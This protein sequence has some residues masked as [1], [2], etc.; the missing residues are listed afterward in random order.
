MIDNLKHVFRSLDQKYQTKPEARSPRKHP[1]GQRR[2]ATYEHFM[3]KCLVRF[4]FASVDV[5]GH[6]VL[7][8]FSNLTCVWSSAKAPG[9]NHASNC[10]IGLRSAETV[11]PPLTAVFKYLEF[12]AWYGIKVFSMTPCMFHRGTCWDI[13]GMRIQI[14]SRETYLDLNMF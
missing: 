13:S 6:V 2:Q 5:C 7:C 14:R 11:S 3:W 1:A 9:L 12:C 4:L 10:T 8:I